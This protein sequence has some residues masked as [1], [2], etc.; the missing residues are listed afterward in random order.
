MKQWIMLCVL[1]SSV[2]L[3]GCEK[4]DTSER[5]MVTRVKVVELGSE[6][7]SDS[8]YFPAVANAADRSHLSFRVAGEIN[9]LTIKEGDRVKQGDV[10]ATLDPTDYQLDVDNAK[11]RFTVIDSQYTRSSPLVEKGLLAKSQF[12]EIAA[13]RQIA[14]AE[15]D[16]AKLRLSF[17]QLKA[18]VDGIISRVNADQFENVQVG[19][20]IVNIHSIDSVE[21]LIQLPD[22]LYISQPKSVGLERMEALVRVPSGNTYTAMVKEFTTE[23]NPATGTFSVT[24]SLPMPDQE[25]ILDGMAVE[26]TTQ[27]GQAGLQLNAG[28]SVPIEAVFN[29]DGDGLERENKFVWILNDDN[30]VSKK[31]VMLGKASMASVQVL[32]GLSASDTVVTA[33]LS[34][35][36]E[37]TVVEVVKQEAGNE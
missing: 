2:L 18:P 12:D 21:V 29:A 34:R 1:S 3:T 10:L 27:G 9:Q 22:R 25:Y 30:T 26:V 6:K 11:A 13:Q 7:L 32:D 16:L 20:Q 23:P 28:V 33:G 5:D 15:L 35:L 14:K 8:L 24:H 31:H 19:Q 4:A 37:G 36:R 17:T